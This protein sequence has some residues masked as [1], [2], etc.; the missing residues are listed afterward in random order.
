MRQQ[1][2]GT[3]LLL[4]ERADALQ[5]AALRLDPRDIRGEPAL[6]TLRND[7]LDPG[8]NTEAQQQGRHI[9]DQAAAGGAE[10]DAPAPPGTQGDAAIGRP[11]VTQEER[12]LIIVEA[13]DTFGKVF[14]PGALAEDT[15]RL[16]P[17]SHPRR[18][19]AIAVAGNHQLVP[20]PAPGM[21]ADSEAER[22]G[23]FR[24]RPAVGLAGGG[25]TQ[26]LAGDIAAIPHQIN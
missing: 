26:R 17:L 13:E 15:Q 22:F 24:H 6:T 21:T 11:Q 2:G 18:V 10:I 25:I 23:G 14:L 4:A 9:I 16:E 3:S 20:A 8:L 12:Q 19:P 1:L 7:M 5:E